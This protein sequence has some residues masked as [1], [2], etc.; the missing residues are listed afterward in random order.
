M[1]TDRLVRPGSLWRQVEV[2][3]ATGSTNADLAALAAA[4]AAMPGTALV[5]D[6][7]TAGRGRFT[8]AWSTPPGVS[9]ATSVFVRPDV[10]PARWSW[11][12]LMTG[13]AVAEGV[14][15]A[16]GLPV[17][18]K[19]PNDVLVGDRKL[20]GLLAEVVVTP[21]GPGAVIGF[22]INVSMDA[23][24]LPTS[25]ATSLLLE[26]AV[27]DKTDLAAEVLEAFGRAYRLWEREPAVL[28]AAYERGCSTI[29]RPVRVQ[30]TEA[31]FVEGVAVGVDE[32]GAIVV[33]SA[34]GE[35]AYAAGD[36]VHLR[37]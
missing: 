4:G 16:A 13:V 12:P 24:E 17:Q 25:T 21:T 29:G 22:G 36:V 37:L 20:C 10:E 33:R 27:V 2:V 15:R 11:L 1:L 5:T 30:L 32:A 35:R 28:R 14:R 34:A 3:A 7:Q 6:N 26:G 19:W 23:A 18:L 8:R 9:L 31:E